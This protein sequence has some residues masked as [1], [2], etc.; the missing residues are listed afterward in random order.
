MINA[1]QAMPTGGDL[2]LQLRSDN[3]RATIDV[4]DT[5]SGIPAE[6]L[7]R[8]FDAYYTTKR[9]GTGLGLAMS[10]RIAQ[11]HGGNLTVESDPGKG[12]DFRLT[13]PMR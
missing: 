8:I 11:E 10:K 6:K 12:S 13:L 5:G 9:G 7:P 2:I 4:I 1:V 3:D